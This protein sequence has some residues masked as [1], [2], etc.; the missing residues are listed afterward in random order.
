MQMKKILFATFACCASI[1]SAHAQSADDSGFHAHYP[2]HYFF[3]YNAPPAPSAY[4][5][6]GFM[7][8]ENRGYGDQYLREQEYEHSHGLKS[9]STDCEFASCPCPNPFWR[10]STNCAPV[11][12]PPHPAPPD[13]PCTHGICEQGLGTNQEETNE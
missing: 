7:S 5:Q 13:D 4:G 2:Q 11:V 6:F 9:S 8:G 1:M 12:I 10:N 3:P